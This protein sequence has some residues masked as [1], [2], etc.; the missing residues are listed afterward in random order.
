MAVLGGQACPTLSARTVLAVREGV[1][2]TFRTYAVQCAGQHS[3]RADLAVAVNPVR[4]PKLRQAI[5]DG[6]LHRVTCPYCGRTFTVEKPF[7]YTDLKR[8]LVVQ[9][10]PPGH[11]YRWREASAELDA[12]LDAL[13]AH[14]VLKPRLRRRVAFGIGE[15][16]EKLVAEDA[17]M[18]D[19]HI[20]LAKVLAL[21]EQSM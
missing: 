14:G 18:D 19:R 4:M 17:R 12:G 3:F 11:A 15:L 16:R 10:R 2:S 21:H 6:S 5:I 13:D 1:L 20:E 8:G 7:V 9:V